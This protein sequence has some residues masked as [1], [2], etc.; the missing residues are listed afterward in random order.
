MLLGALADGISQF[1]SPLSAADT[2]A[3]AEAMRKAGCT[4]DLDETRLVVS[5][6]PAGLT[7]NIGQV[8]CGNSGTTMRLLA[9]FMTGNSIQGVLS[10]DSS[11]LA[12]PMGR[13]IQPLNRMGGAVTGAMDNSQAP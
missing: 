5:P 8:D 1:E 3:T 12:R 4:V 11:L 13:I 7:Q 9:G 10:G 2:Q 6:P